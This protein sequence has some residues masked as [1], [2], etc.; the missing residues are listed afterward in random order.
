MI[1]LLIRIFFIITAL[2]LLLIPLYLTWRLGAYRLNGKLVKAGFRLGCIIVG[3][4]V[5]TEGSISKKRPLLL[6]SN[7]FSYLDVF[8]LG[9]LTGLR[10]TPKSDV[11]TW[12]V[13][14]FFCKITGCIFID[15]RPSQ[16]KNNK[17]KLDK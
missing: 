10:F 14:G 12:P 5:K 16:T 1:R 7:H 6:V 2:L 11:A 8:V 4:K 13:I 15:R 3:I 17:D 9:S